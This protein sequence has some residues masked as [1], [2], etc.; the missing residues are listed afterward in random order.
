MT[1]VSASTLTDNSSEISRDQFLGTEVHVDD[2]IDD[3]VV[4]EGQEADGVN[5]QP[6]SESSFESVPVSSEP[7][8]FDG[9]EPTVEEET[10]IEGDYFSNC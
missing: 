10:V 4:T 6:I 2:S 7:A 1:A 9:Y 3:N 5:V 8:T